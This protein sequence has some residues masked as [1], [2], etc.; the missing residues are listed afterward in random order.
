MKF[1][2][3]FLVVLFAGA[4]V[5]NAPAQETTPK[6]KSF[7]PEWLEFGGYYKN[8]FVTSETTDTEESYYADINRLRLDA[9]AKFSEKWQARIVYDNELILNDFANRSDFNV[10]RESQPSDLV[11]WD[12]RDVYSDEPDDHIFAQ[13]KLYRAYISYYDPGFQATVGKQK[14]DWGRGRF[15]SPMDLFNPVSPIAVEY[16][17]RIGADAVNIEMP[18][19]TESTINAVY[20]VQERPE[21]AKAAVRFFHPWSTYDVGWM[22]GEF[23]DD[24]VVGGMVD[25]YL[26]DSGVRSE[27]TYTWA[28]NEREFWRFMAGLEHQFAKL[29][30]LVEYFYNGGADDN[31]SSRFLTDLAYADRVRSLQ[32][33]LVG[34]WTDYKLTP[35]L[36]FNNYVIYD[37][38]QES[39]FV[40]PELEYNLMENL[41]IAVGAQLPWGSNDSE[42]GIYEELYYAKAQL[43]F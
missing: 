22:A 34:L 5:S 29:H 12:A 38:D 27:W 32:K 13:H 16:E 10:I 17:E 6:Q 35:L 43:F 3:F 23:N 18:V 20:A 25:G 40:S 39:V 7:L 26:A 2:I 4:P 31:D 37:I 33:N 24:T 30:V 42:F 41:D 9:K 11:Y 36:V 28:D 14:I 8:L 1:R 19:G 15:Y 21:N